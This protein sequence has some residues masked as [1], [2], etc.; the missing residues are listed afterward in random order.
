M[1]KKEKQVKPME[2]PICGKFFF[3][4]LT[5]DDIAA[6]ETPNEQ[7]CCFCGWFYDLEQ[8]KN[9]DLENQSNKMSLN[10][11]KVWYKEKIKQNHRWEYYRENM[12][13]PEPHVCPVCGEYTF[14]DTLSY[15]VCPVCGWTDYGTEN[16]P[17]ETPTPYLMSLNDRKVWFAKQREQNSKFRFVPLGRPKGNKNKKK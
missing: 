13:K 14:K 16:E 12:G 7:Q 15:D 1:D 3:T 9:P 17:D 2:C 8:L 4:K 6:G 5:E 11:Y 10:E